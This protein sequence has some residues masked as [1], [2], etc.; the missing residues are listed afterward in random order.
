MTWTPFECPA[1]RVPEYVVLILR[2]FL[3]LVVASGTS[4]QGLRQRISCP[5]LYSIDD[6]DL[7]S[8]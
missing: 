4:R 3:W 8:I 7:A 6:C 2:R 1:S 5:L